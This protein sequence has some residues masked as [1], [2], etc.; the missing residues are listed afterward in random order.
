MLFFMI[1]VLGGFEVNA[2]E[3]SKVNSKLIYEAKL[4]LLQGEVAFAKELIQQI[5][6]ETKEIL[7][8]KVLYFIESEDIERAEK[9]LRR[10]EDS[11]PNDG[12]TFAFSS[13]V[14][15]SIGHQASLFS[16]RGFYKKAIKAKIRAGD[17]AP[18]NPRYLILKASAFGQGNFGGDLEV[19]AELTR[20]IQS[21]DVK[22][23]DLAQLNLLQNQGK[24]QEGKAL[25]KRMME[26]YPDDF[27]V[28]ERAGQFYWSHNEHDLSQ[29]SFYLACMNKPEF[30]WHKQVKWI[31]ACYQTAHFAIENDQNATQ[32]SESLGKLMEEFTLYT[33]FNLQ[34]AELLYSLPNSQSKELA[35]KFCQQ[36]VAAGSAPNL[37]KRAKALIRLGLH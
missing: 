25:A 29:T 9:A 12:A 14:W 3:G 6:Q 15:R 22:W 2:S 4:Q 24:E 13:E 28:L 20:L 7:M 26:K 36:L 31:N 23:G 5:K 35:V 8:L 11:Y 16:K 27:D 30:S 10:F 17:I 19:Q 37:I 33:D 32:G 18:D 21:K 1:I 34:T